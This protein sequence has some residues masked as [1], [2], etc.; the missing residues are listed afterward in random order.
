MAFAEIGEMCDA[1]LEKGLSGIEGTVADTKNLLTDE[2]NDSF[3]MNAALNIQRNI[4]QAGALRTPAPG[5]NDTAR[6]IAGAVYE[7]LS[8]MTFAASISGSPNMKRFFE[9][10]RVEAKL[11]K[12]KTGQEAFV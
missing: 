3:S 11:F 8:N 9:D 12:N 5:G 4:G 2:M 10:M 7:A 6:T 1:G